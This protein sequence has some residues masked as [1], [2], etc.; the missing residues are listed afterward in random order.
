M[1]LWQYLLLL[2][3]GLAVV[4]VACLVPERFFRLAGRASAN[5]AMGMALLLLI[6]AC[7]GW[8][9]LQLPV[10]GLTLAV[11][12]LLGAPGMASLAVI[13]AI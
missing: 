3:A 2:L 7:A 1:N 8:T 4:F 10:N 6:N 11:S 5:V 9:A 12:A 13:A